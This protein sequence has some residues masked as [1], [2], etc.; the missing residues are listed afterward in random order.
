M[1][2]ADASSRAHH[3]HTPSSSLSPPYTDVEVAVEVAV[4]MAV[5]S[6]PGKR[7]ARPADKPPL[8]KRPR[9]LTCHDTVRDAWA[10]LT[11]RF[12]H[13]CQFS[14]AEI[15]HVANA[16]CAA[17]RGKDKRTTRW[18]KDI[19]ACIRSHTIL[20][21]APDTTDDIYVVRDLHYVP[22][23]NAK[24]GQ[25]P[26]KKD[27]SDDDAKLCEEQLSRATIPAEWTTESYK[28][29]RLSTF[30]KSPAIQ[31]VS[32]P[33]ENT[34]MG[35]KGYRMVRA[36]SA[37]SEGDWYFEAKLISYAGNGAVRLGW[38]QRRSDPE[39]P[40]GFDAYG[41]GCR[42]R[43]GHFVHAARVRDY[44]QPF[45]E[46]DV[47]GCRVKLPNL[48]DEQKQLIAQCDEKWLNHRFINL[49]QGQPPPDCDIDIHGR[50]HVQFF[51]NGRDMGI[52]AFFS[53]TDPVDAQSSRKAAVEKRPID[54]GTKK[55]S[56]N[57][58]RRLCAGR[59]YPSISLYGN[60]VV[61]ANFG[62]D[63][64]FPKPDE[65]KA[66]CE[67]ARDAPPPKPATDTVDAG[68]AQGKDIKRAGHNEKVAHPSALLASITQDAKKGGKSDAADNADE[69]LLSKSSLPLGDGVHQN[70][71][72]QLDAN[73][74]GESQGS[75]ALQPDVDARQNDKV[76]HREK[77]DADTH[78]NESVKNFE[79]RDKSTA[80]ANAS[81]GDSNDR[82]GRAESAAVRADSENASGPGT[83][84]TPSQ[85][86]S[87]AG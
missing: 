42:V 80:V 35:H 56:S 4:E 71:H 16:Q 11:A 65:S 40:V 15:V 55:S 52:P 29:V 82:G 77:L 25:P 26:K 38:S 22:K 54:H 32:H 2:V 47:I 33:T 68:Q 20:A 13:R 31:F 3:A 87:G 78:D 83:Q 43:T 73:H 63:F 66:M 6:A 7:L 79:S 48:S 85:S 36:T 23:P 84:A 74:Y 58:K 59:F 81:D 53:K 10:V 27:L 61:K 17:L 30:D 69:P 18:K 9:R 46:G 44:A 37:V 28:P 41:Y 57:S 75:D 67:A 24:K 39:T 34:V 12:P 8:Q 60:A 45:E 76:N 51:K 14:L 70:G 86:Y 19:T 49:L 64:W 21:R 1:S 62:P 72:Q 5:E 50:A